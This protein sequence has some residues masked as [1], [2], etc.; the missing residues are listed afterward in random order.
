MVFNR[1]CEKRTGLVETCKRYHNFHLF[2]AKIWQLN[3]NKAHFDRLMG[4][5]VATDL[6]S[7]EILFVQH[8]S[9]YVSLNETMPT[10]T[11]PLH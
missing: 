11:S 7:K 5:F 6:L 10:V 9:N 2:A 4:S 1:N 3:E 8:L